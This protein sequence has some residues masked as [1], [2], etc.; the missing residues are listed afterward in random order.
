MVHCAVLSL[1]TFFLTPAWAVQEVRVGAAH[2]P[3]YTVRP[4]IGVDTGLLPQL[5]DALNQLQG[6]YHFV[7]VPTSNARR[8]REFEQ[9]RMDM[10]LFENPTWGWNT[11]AHNPVDMGLEDVEVFVAKRQP[12]R[13]H[14]Y[15]G[16]L[17]NK[18]LALFNGYHYAFAGFN[19]SPK[20]LTEKFHASLTYSHASNL[21]MVLRGRADIALITRSH[22]ID[23]LN[24]NPQ[25]EPTV[26][27]SDRVDYIYHHYAL[28]SPRAPIQ[29]AQ[30]AKMLQAL[31]DNGQFASIFAPYKI[32]QVPAQI[33]GAQAV[34]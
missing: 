31:R 4:E 1:G 24:K 8:Y 12:G 14:T 13:G 33:P 34:P 2:F 6:D 7:I 10:V 28:L 15:F 22:L 20:A 30:L 21:Q 16:D 27:V 19:T 18:R 23:L 9:G 17:A 11:I 25:I 29:G 5:L 32:A 26:L 3:P